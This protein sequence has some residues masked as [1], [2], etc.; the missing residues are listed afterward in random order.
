MKK[1]LI[2]PV[3]LMV[4]AISVIAAPLTKMRQVS[5]STVEPEPM[6]VPL[7]QNL[8]MVPLSVPMSTSAAGGPAD[9]ITQPLYTKEGK[10]IN[11][12]RGKDG[13]KVG[14]LV[15]EDGNPIMNPID[16]TLTGF[17]TDSQEYIDGANRKLGI[18][19]NSFLDK[20]YLRVGVTAVEGIYADREVFLIRLKTSKTTT[21][22]VYAFREK[23]KKG[24]GTIFQPGKWFN[25]EYRYFDL[26][27][28][29]IKNEFITSWDTKTIAK[30]AL[31]NTLWFFATG[32]PG[33]IGQWLFGS[34]D[35]FGVPYVK[36]YEKTTLRDLMEELSHA[37][38]HPYQTVPDIVTEDGEPIYIRPSTKQCVSRFNY[39]LFHIESG[40]PLVFI[41]GSIVTTKLFEPEIR[42]GILRD[43]VSV[44]QLLESGTP[45]Y[46]DI[47]ETDFG[48]IDVVVF[49]IGTVK[50]PEWVL[51]N[52]ESTKGF[53]KGLQ[54]AAI[55]DHDGES[56]GQWVNRVLLGGIFGGSGKSLTERIIDFLW[57]VVLIIVAVVAVILGYKLIKKLLGSGGKNKRNNYYKRN[58]R[59][60]RRRWR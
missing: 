16:F 14:L 55:L 60:Q 48:E 2:I 35:N 50:N 36:V 33:L 6:A 46:I 10:K 57:L 40:L 39:P 1:V 56:F 37:T 38:I 28:V 9:L 44:E 30:S 59:N 51:P 49:N 29:Q 4:A 54:F 22:E 7:S 58:Y 12:L 21:K 27:M 41:D 47:A 31:G 11:M 19:F 45:Y 20:H 3:I 42:D 17:D 18:Y 15:T 25:D 13:E 43:V 26:N 8:D 5:A 53:T 24:F 23:V 32:I 34:A 52:G